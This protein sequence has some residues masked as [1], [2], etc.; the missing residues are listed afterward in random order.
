MC[1]STVVSIICGLDRY[2]MS[3]FNYISHLWVLIRMINFDGFSLLL[4]IVEDPEV[5]RR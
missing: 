1:I 2:L 4:L 5:Y 3:A